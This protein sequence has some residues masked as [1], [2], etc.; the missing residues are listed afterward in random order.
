MNAAMCGRALR[1]QA[2][3][4]DGVYSAWARWAGGLCDASVAYRPFP[5]IRRYAA[6]RRCLCKISTVCGP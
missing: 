4:R 2:M 1:P 5:W 3:S 6:T